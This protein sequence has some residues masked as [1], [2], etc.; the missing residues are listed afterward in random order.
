[1]AT[2]SSSK[3][4]VGGGAAAEISARQCMQAYGWRL[5]LFGGIPIETARQLSRIAVVAP[6]EEQ[7]KRGFERAQGRVFLT[8][9]ASRVRAGS[10]MG[11]AFGSVRR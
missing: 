9:F 2:R 5:P 7:Y 4:G 11:S 1:M 3:P 6:V 10:G 8:G